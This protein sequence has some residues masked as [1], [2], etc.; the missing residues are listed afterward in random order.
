MPKIKVE[1]T[2]E[3][4]DNTVNRFVYIVTKQVIDA[5]G[6]RHVATFR[7]IYADVA[8]MYAVAITFG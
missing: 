5:Y 7:T 8:Q 4:T 2:C 1:V 6:Q 3:E